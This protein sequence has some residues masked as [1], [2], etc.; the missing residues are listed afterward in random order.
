MHA[1]GRLWE[2]PL[3]ALRKRLSGNESRANK[4]L[5]SL[6]RESDWIEWGGSLIGACTVLVPCAGCKG[7]L[8]Q[9]SRFLWGSGCR[10]FVTQ[11]LAP[12]HIHSNPGG[13]LPSLPPRAKK[14]AAGA[15]KHLDKSQ[16]IADSKL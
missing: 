3:R 4:A 15:A 6:E 1:R 7:S 14:V 9:T 2:P 16:F 12:S 10:V 5:C 11:A 8:A 13:V